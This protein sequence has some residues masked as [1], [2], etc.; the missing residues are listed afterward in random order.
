ML[1]FARVQLTGSWDE[2]ASCS[3]SSKACLSAAAGE[4]LSAMVACELQYGGRSLAA[5]SVHLVLAA[6]LPRLGAFFLTARNSGHAGMSSGCGA[7]M[8]KAKRAHARK[9]QTPCACRG[10]RLGSLVFDVICA[11]PRSLSAPNYPKRFV[12]YALNC[13]ALLG[14]ARAIDVPAAVQFL[15]AC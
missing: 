14:S 9:H 10:G 11:K 5:P 13:C 8:C 7:G 15:L 2:G 3:R 4:F 1:W 12:Y 6:L